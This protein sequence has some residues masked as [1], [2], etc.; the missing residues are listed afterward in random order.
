MSRHWLG[1]NRH[2]F[3]HNQSIRHQ[4]GF[5]GAAPAFQRAAYTQTYST[6]TKTLAAYTANA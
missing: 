6:T 2:T 4:T 1:H 3:P 5:F